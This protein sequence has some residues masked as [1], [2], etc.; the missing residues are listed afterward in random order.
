[1]LDVR[2]APTSATHRA[3]RGFVLVGHS[4]GSRLLRKLLREEIDPRPALRRDLVSAILPGADVLVRRG[5]DRGGDFRSVPLCH[6]RSQTGCV[7]AWSTYGVTPPDDARFGRTPLDDAASPGLDLPSGRRYEVA[8]TNPASLAAQPPR[9]HARAGPQRAAAGDPRASSCCG[10]TAALRPRPT[11]RGWCRPSATPLAASAAAAPTC[12]R[13][14]AIGDA[15]QLQPA[16]DDTWGLH[17]LDVNIVLGD[18]L[19]VLRAQVRAYL[20][21]DR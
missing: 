9:A 5:S 15:R 12:S 3:G 18:V 21:R 8:C 13:C 16:P 1:M 6:R 4:Q 14:G 10:C 2:G 19:T 11:R 7:L 20:R 17:L